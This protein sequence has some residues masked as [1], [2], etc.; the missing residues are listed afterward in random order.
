M[1][2]PFAI[3]VVT[4]FPFMAGGVLAEPISIQVLLE[5]KEQVRFEF[6]DGSKHFVLAVRREGMAEGSGAF[7]GAAVTEMGWH[8]V[9]PGV[10]GEPQGY[11][12]ITAENGDVAILRWSARATF[13][14]GEG[15]KPSLVNHGSWE[16]VSGTG[17]FQ[18]KRGVGSLV[19]EPQGGPNLFTIQGE[20]GDKS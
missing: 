3:A 19:I 11:L 10:S 9:V 1:R 14:K 13:V 15:G 18:E 4:A 20:V 8:D 12:Q 16:L 2:I 6:A 17:E 5:P 7:E